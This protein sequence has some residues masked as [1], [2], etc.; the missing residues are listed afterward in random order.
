METL[1]QKVQRLGVYSEVRTLPDGSIAAVGDLIFT[2][3]IYLGC[4]EIGWSRRFCFDDRPRANEEFKKLQS[5]DD[6]P[7]GWIARR[8]PEDFKG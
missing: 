7:S 1:E 6:T 2:R 8:P 4:D 5:R 3:A